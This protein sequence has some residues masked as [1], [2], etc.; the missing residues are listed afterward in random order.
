MKRT[1]NFEQLQET[2]TKLTEEVKE[3]KKE[4]QLNRDRQI[5]QTSKCQNIPSI[6]RLLFEILKVILVII[7]YY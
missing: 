6:G 3:I 2:T 7:G 1:F 5:L 4:L